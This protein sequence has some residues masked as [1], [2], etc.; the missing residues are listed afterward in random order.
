MKVIV[1]CWQVKATKTMAGVGYHV[2]IPPLVPQLFI[3]IL[4]KATCEN[5]LNNK[6][7]LSQPV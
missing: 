4:G 2:I 3:A 7:L 5:S 1:A 6:N